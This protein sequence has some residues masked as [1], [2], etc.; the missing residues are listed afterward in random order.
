MQRQQCT[1][2]DSI[3]VPKSSRLNQYQQL[4]GEEKKQKSY[5][6]QRRELPPLSIVAKKLP[7]VLLVVANGESG[8]ILHIKASAV[9]LYL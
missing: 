2:M 1:A 5:S 3:L 8:I 7:F 9:S 6:R 4:F